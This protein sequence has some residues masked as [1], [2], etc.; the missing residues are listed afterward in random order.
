MSKRF[1]A[2]L[3]ALCMALTLLPEAALAAEN[4]SG[5][6]Y[7]TKVYW[8]FDA[9]HWTLKFSGTGSMGRGAL[10]GEGRPWGKYL[11]DIRTVIV[12]S[13]ITS[14]RN[15]A[16]QECENL[17]SVILPG[18]LEKI[19]DSAFAG[20]RSLQSIDM[21]ASVTDLD[22]GAP[23]VFAR[24][25]SL[26]NISVSPSNPNDAS[27]GDGALYSKDL[28]ALLYVP[29]DLS[30]T[31]K[32]PHGVQEIGA[33]AFAGKNLS[34][35]ILPSSI[36]KIG[37][38]AFS[39]SEVSSIN[40]P[41]NVT[42]IGGSAFMHCDNI[43][44]FDIPA[45]VTSIGDWAFGEMFNKEIRFFG[46]VP[47]LGKNCFKGGNYS[48]YYP[49]RN[50]SWTDDVMQDYG[51]TNITWI[52]WDP[53]GPGTPDV[54][55]TPDD[56]QLHGKISVSAVYNAE[57]EKVTLRVTPDPGYKLALFEVT[58]NDGMR[59]IS[60]SDSGSTYTFLMPT[61]DVTVHVKFTKI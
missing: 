2:E 44:R 34:T 1:L 30:G 22:H 40:I 46:K 49:A 29:L 43:T 35:I 21:P 60:L 27:Y 54:P 7:N 24:C 10:Y 14:I 47:A 36:T 5:K 56:G 57:G 25:T 48:I 58:D 39:G 23:G 45:S 18:T 32:V 31:F 11:A 20:C 6:L 33:N 42:E 16:L 51:G 28:Q 37:M 19:G 50:A 12:G 26:R 52:P 59:P 15:C 61:Y 13:G 53:Y 41:S 38:G 8:E 55:D 4:P 17:T 9:E 3:F